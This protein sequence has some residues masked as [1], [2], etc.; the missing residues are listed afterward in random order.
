[1]SVNDVTFFET[2]RQA[3]V[4]GLRGMLA[5]LFARLVAYL[6][7]RA[8]IASLRS[9]SDRELKDI[10]VYRCDIDRIAH[11]GRDDAIDSAL[12]TRSVSTMP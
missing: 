4:P 11:Q 1:M 9:M 7:Q 2:G 10:G 5:Q 8:D 6:Q 12:R 3:A